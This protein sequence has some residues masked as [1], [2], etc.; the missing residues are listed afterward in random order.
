MAENIP[1]LGKVTGIQVQEIQKA[2]SNI[3]LID[4]IDATMKSALT[5]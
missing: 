4:Y 5:N 1:N 3:R 2:P